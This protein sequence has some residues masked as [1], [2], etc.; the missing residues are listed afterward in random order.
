MFRYCVK[1]FIVTYWLHTCGLMLLNSVKACIEMI[2][3]H[4]CICSFKCILNG[5]LSEQQR[6]QE[7]ISFINLQT[8]LTDIPLTRC[9]TFKYFFFMMFISFF[10]FFFSFFIQ[11]HV[12]TI[13]HSGFGVVY[14]TV[15]KISLWLRNSGELHIFKF[16]DRSHI[17]LLSW[18]KHTN[19]VNEH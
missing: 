17:C 4:L 2:W 18:L 9:T 11:D 14:D 5:A 10:F 19:R 12:N 3:L 16:F 8:F 13:C 1:S 15:I 7:I 6:K